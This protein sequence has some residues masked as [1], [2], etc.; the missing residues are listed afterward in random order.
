M[1][2]THI[3]KSISSSIKIYSIPERIWDNITNVKIE[4]FSDPFIFKIL[5]V[6]KPLTAEII[7]EGEG[8]SRVAYFNTGKKFLQ[9]IIVWKPMTE[10]SFTFNPEKGFRVGYFFELS[11]G[12]FRILK[13]AYYLRQEADGITLQLVTIYSLDKNIFVLF[14]LPVRLILTSFQKY[15]LRFIKNNAEQ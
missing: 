1:S 7:S 2:H 13:G 3:E 15:L 8:G 12:I 4:Q 10:Y 5:N 11:E 14:N 9:K 6:P